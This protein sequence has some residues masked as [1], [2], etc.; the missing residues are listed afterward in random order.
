M[1][2][3]ST[4]DYAGTTNGLTNYE[5][6]L[7]NFSGAGSTEMT[8]YGQ[9]TTNYREPDGVSDYDSVNYASQGITRNGLQGEYNAM[10]ASVKQNGGLN[11]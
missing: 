10:I 1:A 11:R 5:G 6:V 7:Y 8:N 4:G 2:K 3:E 9:G